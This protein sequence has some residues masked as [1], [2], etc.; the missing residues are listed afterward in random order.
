MAVEDVRDLLGPSSPYRELTAALVSKQKTSKGASAYARFLNRPAGRYI[1]ALAFKLRMTPNAVTAIS[2]AC[3]FS[4]IALIALAPATVGISAMI[5]TLL[6]LGYALDSAD[7][8]L[9]R[10]QGGGSFAGEWLDHV[11]DAAKMGSLHL[12]VLVSWYHG[13]ALSPTWLV[14]P[15][16]YQ[17]LAVVLFFSI[18]LTDQ[19]RRAHRGS[20]S[21]RLAGEG[22]SSFVYS[23]AVLPTEYGVLA[24]AF[25][26]WAVPS[27]FSVVYTAFFAINA[28]FFLMALP[29]WYRE[30]LSYG[31]T[32]VA[33]PGTS[34]K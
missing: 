2:A 10:L 4:G 21:T 3:S 11:V 9:A 25:G 19:M 12:A 17:F 16:L 28:C 8:Q 20:A 27:A 1:A 24:L 31:R 26:L 32:D 7:G 29:R 15:L 5:V 22:T 13:Y 18:I 14:V 23:L 34:S 30:M 6:V 33:T